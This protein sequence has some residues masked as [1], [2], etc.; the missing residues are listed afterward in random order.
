VLPLL[1]FRKEEKN[2]ENIYTFKI[3]DTMPVDERKLLGGATTF[4][5]SATPEIDS[6]PRVCP[7]SP[8]VTPFCIQLLNY[9]HIVYREGRAPSY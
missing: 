7:A 8:Y 6:V 3:H 2:K 5:F 1:T 9:I 4:F